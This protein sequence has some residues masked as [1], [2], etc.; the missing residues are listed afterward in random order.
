M[1]IRAADNPPRV[2]VS[3]AHERRDE[4]HGEQV[5]GLANR[6][7]GDGVDARIDLYEP[8]PGQGWPKWCEQELL[9][10]AVVIVVCT[11]RYRERFEGDGEAGAGSGVR[12]EGSILRQLLCEEHAIEVVPVLLAGARSDDVPTVLRGLTRRELPAE[13]DDLYRQLTGQPAVRMPGLG[14]LRRR[15]DNLRI[16]SMPPVFTGRREELAEIGKALVERGTATVHPAIVGLGGVG[17]TRLALEYARSSEHEY[18]V[19]WK[20]RAS[21]IASAQEDLVALGQE[22]GILSRPE[23]VEASVGEV[24]RWLSLHERWLLVLDNAEDAESIRPLLP[25]ACPGH[26]LITSRAQAWRGLAVPIVLRAL[27]PEAARELLLRRSGQP[28]DGCVDALAKALGYLPL[29]LVQAA[30][31]LECTQESFARYLEEFEASDLGLFDEAIASPGDGEEHT[32]ARTWARS[33]AKVEERSP[34]AARLLEVLAFLDPDGVPMTLLLEH[35][36]GLPVTIP[37]TRSEL[38]VAVSVLL[39][40]SLVDRAADELRVHRL[41]QQASREALGED[42][43]RGLAS[44]VVRWV[45][46][47][48]AYEPLVTSVSQV[49]DGIAE[50]L[51]AVATRPECRQAEGSQVTGMLGDLGH[52]W[53]L[54]GMTEAALE[55][56]RRS[57]HV[58]EVLAK[59]DPQSTQAQ[60]DLSVSLNK[61]GDVEVQA[62]NLT[63][64]RDLFLRCLAI[65]EAMAEADPHS[66]RGQRDLSVS[67][68]KLGNLEV[69]TGRLAAARDLFLRSL[70]IAEAL[71]KANPHSVQAQR[72]LSVSL[73]QL[74]NVE[75]QASNL[76][77]ARDLFLRYLAIAEVLA[78][79]D[80]HNAQAQRDLSVSLSQLGNVEVKTGSLAVARDLFLRYLAI[81]EALAKAD[82]HNAQAQRDLSVSL[83]QLGNLEVQAGNLAAAHDLFLRSLHLHEALAKVDP[84]SAQAAFDLVKSLE[85]LAWLAEKQGDR[86]AEFEHLRRASALLAAMD[87]R[88]HIQGYA[89][90]ERLV[91]KIAWQLSS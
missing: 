47:V 86:T 2:F 42:A 14:E 90:R 85:F 26:V 16:G 34:V 56:G 11:A 39:G 6:L 35:G 27:P 61:L 50:Q 45:R 46:R 1:S 44:L 59:A 91:Q 66:A 69:Q 51:M 21:N 49:V 82:P 30:A 72:D 81:A 19:R 24:Q 83:N 77:V 7:R 22:L 37:R 33:F 78:K 48:F 76:T 87:A 12:W 67:W 20:V 57:L 75:L 62:G 13:Y 5:L 38:N 64:A 36:E 32:V 3:W 31:Y 79:A 10:A 52:F 8:S 43:R 89:E 58:A 71:A 9:A 63:A 73:N 53:S 17:K 80:P 23:D 88:G 40:F 65:A 18:E 60:H 70:A 4:G 29:A 55:A 54:R 74:G 41:V 28:N 84:H 15:V 68:N 25:N